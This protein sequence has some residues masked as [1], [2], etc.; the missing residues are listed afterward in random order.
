MKRKRIFFVVADKNIYAYDIKNY[1]YLISQ[2]LAPFSDFYLDKIWKL[3]EI[4]EQKYLI[5]KEYSICINIY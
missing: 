3:N 2:S 4:N 5:L 1:K